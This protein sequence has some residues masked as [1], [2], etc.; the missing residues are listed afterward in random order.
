MPF[1]CEQVETLERVVRVTGD[2]LRLLD[3]VEGRPLHHH[4]SAEVGVVRG[5]RGLWVEVS[6]DLDVVALPRGEVQPEV[7]RPEDRRQVG[8][9]GRRLTRSQQ[10][11]DVSERDGIHRHDPTRLPDEV[12]SMLSRTTSSPW[13][14]RTRFVTGSKRR[15]SFRPIRWAPRAVAFPASSTPPAV[16][17]TVE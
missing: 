11:S 2:R 6:A 12:A 7:D 17:S 4:A 8:R 14:A 16:A 9:A 1:A 15:V 3:P 13:W 5:E 10:G